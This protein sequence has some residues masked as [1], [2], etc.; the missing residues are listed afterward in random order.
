MYSSSHN[1]QTNQREDD[2]YPKNAKRRAVEYPE[3]SGQV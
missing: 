2:G 1:H 3:D